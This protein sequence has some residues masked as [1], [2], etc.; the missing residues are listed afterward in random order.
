[1]RKGIWLKEFDPGADYEVARPFRFGGGDFYPG[2][3]FDV[4]TSERQLRIMYENRYIRMVELPT[5]EPVVEDESITVEIEAADPG[6]VSRHLEE[7]SEQIEEIAKK[8]ESFRLLQKPGGWY[9]VIDSDERPVNEKSLRKAD[10]E[11]LLK[12][13]RRSEE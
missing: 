2:E 12:A 9:D 11:K 7:N 1:V 5:E 10:A 3:R 13:S 8:P 4:K 6:D